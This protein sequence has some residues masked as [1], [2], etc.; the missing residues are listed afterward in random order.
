MCNDMLYDEM[1]CWTREYN[2][3]KTRF[4]PEVDSFL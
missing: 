1:N 4:P 3:R 2:K